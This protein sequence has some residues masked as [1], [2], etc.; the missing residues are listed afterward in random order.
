MIPLHVGEL[1]HFMP[2]QDP[3]FVARAILE[4]Q[5]VLEGRVDPVVLPSRAAP[6]D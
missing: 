1:T 6:P 4:P 2:M 3:D 5:A